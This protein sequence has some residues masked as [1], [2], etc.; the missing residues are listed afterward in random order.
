MF[1]AI[2][3]TSNCPLTSLDFAE[4]SCLLS[5]VSAL[6]WEI[7]DHNWRQHKRHICHYIC[8]FIFSRLW[9]SSTPYSAQQTRRHFAGLLE[10]GWHY[11]KELNFRLNVPLRIITVG[12]PLSHFHCARSGVMFNCCMTTDINLTAPNRIPVFPKTKNL[13]HSWAARH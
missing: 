11:D 5:Y 1:I 8:T 3:P 7:S 6:I 9:P 4:L 12:W 13:I 10:M 2:E